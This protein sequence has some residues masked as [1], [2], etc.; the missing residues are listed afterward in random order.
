[1]NCA[2]N[3]ANT[4]NMVIMNS[5]FLVGSHI[6]SGSRPYVNYVVNDR[7]QCESYEQ[8]KKLSA[9][10]TRHIA[11]NRPIKPVCSKWILTHVLEKV[12]ET[13]Y[14]T[15]NNIENVKFVHINK[16]REKNQ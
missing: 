8:N 12:C 16:R 10:N 2:V 13:L 15:T 4:P 1:M 7:M 3:R 6:Q 14:V 11:N 9:L 5:S